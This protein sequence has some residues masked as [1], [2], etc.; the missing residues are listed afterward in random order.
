MPAYRSSPVLKFF[1][2]FLQSL[3]NPTQTDIVLLARIFPFIA[4]VVFAFRG[5]FNRLIYPA[6]T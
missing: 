4:G 5:I 6:D 3:L 2:L 1:F